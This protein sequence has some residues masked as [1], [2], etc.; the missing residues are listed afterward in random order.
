MTHFFP[1]KKPSLRGCFDGFCN[2]F[3]RHGFRRKNDPI[4]YFL[5]SQIVSCQISVKPFQCL[6]AG[7]EDKKQSMDGIAPVPIHLKIEYQI[8][9]ANNIYIIGDHRPL[10]SPDTIPSKLAPPNNTHLL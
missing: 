3:Y 10:G 1:N 9:M 8:F 7:E 5:I 6:L 2:L 4:P